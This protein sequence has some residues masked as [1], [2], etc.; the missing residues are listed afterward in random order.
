MGRLLWLLVGLLFPRFLGPLGFYTHEDLTEL[1]QWTVDAR[2]ARRD[3]AA[4]IEE[5][6]V[7][8]NTKNISPLCVWDTVGS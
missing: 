4:R 8:P 1:E 2:A 6:E 7:S 5:P 3:P